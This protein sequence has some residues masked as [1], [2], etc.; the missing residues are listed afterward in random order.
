MPID[1]VM[2]F[3][4]KSRE[5]ALFRS[6]KK[7]AQPSCRH[8]T[9]GLL[10]ALSGHENRVG[11]CLLLSAK[12]TSMAQTSTSANDPKR[13]FLK[14]KTALSKIHPARESRPAVP[15]PSPREPRPRDRCGAIG[16]G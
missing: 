9:A 11:E 7:K 15:A 2:H 13:T 16:F 6:I 3:K 12:Q 1:A 14:M 4:M 5:G 8:V 10:V